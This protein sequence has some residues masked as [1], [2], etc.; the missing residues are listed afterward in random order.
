M[1]ST[2]EFAEWLKDHHSGKSKAINAR[3]MKQWGSAREIRFIVHDLRIDG[4]PVCSGQDG[5][6]YAATRAELL[7]TLAFLWSMQQDLL[8]AT[9]ALTRSQQQFP[10][11]SGD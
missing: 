8:R 5:Y 1:R 4:V 2:R 9:T 10:K 11:Q 7:E 6:Y 3:D